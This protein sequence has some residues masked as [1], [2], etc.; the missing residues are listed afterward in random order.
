MESSVNL[1][2]A[3]EEVEEI[4]VKNDY[5]T[6]RDE[7]IKLQQ[8]HPA[9]M[10]QIGS[11]LKLCEV[12]SAAEFRLSGDSGGVDH[13]WVLQVPPSS[14]FSDIENHYKN[15]LEALHPLRTRN[16]AGAKLV[17]ELVEKAFVVLSERE[18]RSEFDSERSAAR[19]ES[20]YRTVSFDLMP[21]GGDN[22]KLVISEP[23][24]DSN[25]LDGIPFQDYY[26]F[27]NDRR[28]EKIE[29]GQIWAAHF[30]GN[31]SGRNSRYALVCLSSD[32][33]VLVT[34]LEP[35]PVTASERRW[36]DA[37]L[38]VSCGSFALIM[39]MTCK[40]TWSTISSHKCAWVRGV[41]EDQFEIYPRKGEIWAIYSDWNVDEWAYYSLDTLKD[42]EF[43]LVEIL[44]DFS[45]YT[46]AECAYLA[47]V[48]GFK[49][50]FE[51]K[52]S[53][54][55]ANTT[56]VTIHIRPGMF[57][58]FSHKVPAYIFVGGE[59]DG[60]VEGMFELDQLALPD[61]MIN[62]ISTKKASEFENVSKISCTTIIPTGLSFFEPHWSA[63]DFCRGQIWAVSCGK[64]LMPRQYT[65]LDDV[66]S[67]SEVRVTFLEP[68]PMGDTEI[69]WRKENLP[70][71]C[72]V[73]KA[74]GTSVKIG[75]SQFS[76]LVRFQQR[77]GE[78]YKIWPLKGEIWAVYKD[79]N[80][81]WKQRD[82]D[83][84]QCQVVQVL[85]DS[86][87]GDAGVIKIARLEEVKGCLTFFQRKQCY[88]F[89]LT[90]VVSKAEMLSF[91][92]RIPAFRVPG[93]GRH[94][95]P[96]SAWHLEPNTLPSK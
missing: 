10:D 75:L 89:D 37:G 12:L 51:R 40:V 11:L 19:R 7:L 73:F 31:Y 93:I 9:E 85:S 71:T 82:H 15:T 24:L 69:G 14:T 56:P 68:L 3:L 5:T 6:A 92:H 57:Y 64:D 46:G 42:C 65:R 17:L 27:E 52:T 54:G 45:K 29:A 1:V 2:K 49:R 41:V 80:G 44:S 33:V 84:S 62:G 28:P 78:F 32:E 94:G 35:I 48:D 25:S 18:R 66:V 50:V 43:E 87:E 76:Y 58:M 67:E 53:G 88:G 39:E 23:L 34:W 38:P 90:G 30:K 16:F 13:Y 95:V 77:R 20:G 96:E 8:L 26:N 91:S 74:R 4:I 36:C 86:T 47:K 79:W 21:G 72:G 83:A 55:S 60:V 61:Y 22:K 63:N 81:K 70:I 59:I